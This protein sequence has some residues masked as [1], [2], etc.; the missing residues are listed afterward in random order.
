LV[1]RVIELP[2]IILETTFASSMKLLYGTKAKKTTLLG[3]PL[4]AL[5]SSG[6]WLMYA[7]DRRSWAGFSIGRS[8]V[9]LLQ[10]Y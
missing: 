1:I 10:K 5:F 3:V 9:S 7:C 6:E 2:N 4:E 8:L